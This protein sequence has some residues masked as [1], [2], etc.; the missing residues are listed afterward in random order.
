MYLEFIVKLSHLN[1]R[2]SKFLIFKS[3]PNESSQ[4]IKIYTFSTFKYSLFW[5]DY[6]IYSCPS[7]GFLDRV[8]FEIQSVSMGESSWSILSRPFWASVSL[9]SFL[10][11]FLGLRSSWRYALN[12]KEK[13][14]WQKFNLCLTKFNK[15]QDRRYSDPKARNG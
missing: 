9:I 4:N 12:W 15:K 6:T 11:S 1:Q 2:G 3:F 13:L 7:F 10:T 8:L 5:Q 14:E